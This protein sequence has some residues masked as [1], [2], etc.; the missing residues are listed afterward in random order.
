M[1]LNLPNVRCLPESFVVS[2][3]GPVCN[4]ESLL[5]ESNSKLV[6]TSERMEPIREATSVQ[7]L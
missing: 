6:L 4:I 3:G 5:L 1:I 2:E 7:T